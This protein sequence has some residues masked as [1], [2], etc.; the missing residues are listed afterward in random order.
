M[1]ALLT[2]FG[3]EDGYVGVMKGVI[4]GIAPDATIV[5]LSHDV[6]PQDV[7]TGA[8]LLHTAWRYFPVGAIFLCVVDPG[9]GSERRPIALC[10]AD[11]CFVG[12]DNGLFSYILPDADQAV[13]LDDPRYHLPQTSATFHGRDIFAPCAA[14]LARQTPLAA[15]GSSAPVAD[16]VSLDLPQPHWQAGELMGRI[17]H[18]D[19]YGNLI[20][21][22]GPDLTSRILG[23][24]AT[25]LR[26]GER[27]ITAR[28][29]HFAAGPEGAPFLLRDSSGHLAIAVRNGSA[30]ELLGGQRGQ[31]VSIV[32][33][34]EME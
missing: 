14:W 19:H 28:A 11:R 27:E 10:A 34:S 26:L 2:D 24:T 21:S 16:L 18:S 29:S 7:A 4:L 15:L 23:D 22:F 6:P 32:G 20:T 12:P 3:Q 13:L 33:L 30:A 17:L 8:W 9:V 5:D 31:L 1:I 25:V